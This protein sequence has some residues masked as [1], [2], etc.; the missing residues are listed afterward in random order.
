[1]KLQ[2]N[3]PDEMNEKLEYYANKCGVKKKDLCNVFIGRGIEYFD[4]LTEPAFV[5][6]YKMLISR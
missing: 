6:F 3:I 4:S 5:K 1:M 2:I